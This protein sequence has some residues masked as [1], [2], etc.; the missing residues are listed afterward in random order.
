LAVA[1]ESA[2][3]DQLVESVATLGDAP[4]DAPDAPVEAIE[5]WFRRCAAAADAIGALEATAVVA[6]VP[7]VVAATPDVA[8]RISRS[9][10]GQLITLLRRH[11]RE[12]AACLVPAV[13]AVQRI[14]RDG[15]LF[16]A[17]YSTFD[18]VRAPAAVFALLSRLDGVAT[19]RDALAA[20][21]AETGELRL[22]DALVRELWRV[23]ALRDPAGSDDPPD[24]IAS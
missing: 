10:R 6:G 5:S 16:V 23:G 4:F 20:A 14:E 19:W 15:D 21:R 18:A 8:T 7:P 22:D 1:L 24:T 2:L 9:P 11:R 3:A 12:I 17:G 13:S